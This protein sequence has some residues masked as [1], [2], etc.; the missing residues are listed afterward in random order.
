MK[1][2]ICIALV[3]LSLC[4]SAKGQNDKSLQNYFQEAQREVEV[5]RKQTLSW[6][7]GIEQQAGTLFSNRKV[8][9]PDSLYQRQEALLGE[10]F[11]GEVGQDAYFVWYA[12]CQSAEGNNEDREL[13][14]KLFLGVYDILSTMSNGMSHT[15]IRIPA[16][17]EYF[18]DKSSGS[19]DANNIPKPNRIDETIDRLWQL[20]SLYDDNDGSPLQAQAE[21][22][23]RVSQRIDSMKPLLTKDKYLLCLEKYMR[24]YAHSK[25]D[26]VSLIDK[27]PVTPL[28]LGWSEINS[29]DSIKCS[30]NYEHPELIDYGCALEVDSMNRQGL[31]QIFRYDELPVREKEMNYQL[32]EPRKM[33]FAKRLPDI[34]GLRVLIYYVQMQKKGSDIVLPCWLLVWVNAHGAA[35]D[36]HI[37]AGVDWGENDALSQTLYYLSKDYLLYIR[38]FAPYAEEVADEEGNL[39]D[40]VTK[41]ENYIYAYPATIVNLAIN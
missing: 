36:S 27:V 6:N 37:I 7:C 21:I 18:L 20:V 40:V 8:V 14:Y 23:K 41:D 15:K 32:S 31:N 34:N 17:V 28:P 35:V 11:R 33:I 2:Y 26:V 12:Y 24:L 5:F 4:F 16:Y 13:V 30:F 25:P 39:I 3:L 38:T 1:Q 19:M 29:I 22:L 9:H 10:C